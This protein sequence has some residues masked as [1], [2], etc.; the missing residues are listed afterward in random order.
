VAVDVV[1]TCVVLLAFGLFKAEKMW[2][3]IG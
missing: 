3:D 2:T 1:N